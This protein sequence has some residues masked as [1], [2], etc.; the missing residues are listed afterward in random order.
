M[1]FEQAK[2]FGEIEIRSTQSRKV[3]NIENRTVPE[4]RE[5]F[6]PGEVKKLIIAAS[7]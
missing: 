7:T 3:S 2:Q 5:Y 4:R 1:L 6:T